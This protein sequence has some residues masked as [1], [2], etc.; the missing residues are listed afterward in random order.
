MR[1]K[2]LLCCGAALALMTSCSSTQSAHPPGAGYHP[3]GNATHPSTAAGRTESVVLRPVTTEGVPS[4]GYRA[5]PATDQV[6][7]SSIAEGSP[8]AVDDGIAFCTPTA[9][10]AVACWRAADTGHVLCLRDPWG[11][12]VDEL[13]L[14][15]DFGPVS[16][17][18]HPRPLAL[19]L[20][21]GT[22]CTVRDGGAWSA[23]AAHPDW[24]GTYYCGNAGV[25]WGPPNSNGID[26]SA[27][28]WTVQ[29]G[30]AAGDGPLRTVGVTSAYFVGTDA[31]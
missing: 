20:A 21:D 23:L 26:E 10:F 31:G 7:C 18:P 25:V 30:S 6:Q 11:Q 13:I 19:T 22:H 27:P 17:P 16:A 4:S 5:V 29:I 14:T 3:P 12:V 2:A 1:S 15:D 24:S 8:V 9:S 28:A